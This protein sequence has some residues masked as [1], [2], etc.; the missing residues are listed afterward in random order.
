MPA[1]IIAGIIVVLTIF[2]ALSAVY[3][4]QEGHV[5]IIRT[6]GQATDKEDPGVHVK[7]PWPFQA[8]DKI[9]VRARRN[10][11]SLAAASSK[12]LPIQ[13]EVGFNWAV[14]KEAALDLFIEFG[15]L[16]QFEARVLD[17]RMRSAVKTALAK[18]TVDEMIRG[19]ELAVAEIERTLQL[20][21]EG[22]PV[23]IS[24]AQIENIAPP[25]AY[26]AAVEAKQ[27]ANQDALRQKEILER[28]RLES[29][30]QVNSAEAERQSAV[31]S[32]QGQA[33]AKLLTAQAEADAR[34]VQADAEAHAIQVITAQLAQSP[35]YIEF[36]QVSNWNGALPT[37][38]L[39]DAG[40]GLLLQVPTR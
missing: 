30:Q 34:R 18:F 29:L 15:G 10:V 32:A 16:N 9:E 12:Q 35:R 38:M 20:A 17:P 7:A 36:V 19:R 13:V 25:P 28:Q 4:V 11:E 3:F 33:E 5:A 23:T 27:V 37:T 2:E 39:G 24:Q 1:F 26:M 22:L 31:L 8:V 14:N 40:A 6:F 21:F